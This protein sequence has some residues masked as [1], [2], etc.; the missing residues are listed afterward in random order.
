MKNTIWEPVF[1]PFQQH[2]KTLH[3]EIIKT[4]QFIYQIGDA[5]FLR[6]PSKQV[7]I[8]DI[9]SPEMKKKIGYL[10]KCMLFYRRVTGK[11]RGIA[12]VQLGIPE[13]FSVIYMPEEKQTLQIIINPHIIRSSEKL[14]RYPEICM[15]ANPLIAPV[16]RPAWIEF[17]YYDENGH[18]K[19]WNKKDITKKLTM[20]N[21]VF[22]HEIDH[23]DGIINIDRVS[24]KELIFES[25]PAYYTH[26]KFEEIIDTHNPRIFTEQ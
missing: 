14:L 10:K 8:Q 3:Q 21:R 4:G 19:I 26:A 15:S 23:M 18:K 25:D 2:K 12:A 5:P 1:P 11:G 6:M 7:P 24:S 9:T 20:Y 13:R 22:Q 17:E 16:V